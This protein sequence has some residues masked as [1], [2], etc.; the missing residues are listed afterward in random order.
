MM[1]GKYIFKLER[2]QKAKFLINKNSYKQKILKTA[3]KSIKN[4]E[5]ELNTPLILLI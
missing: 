5:N 3:Y 4:Q 2:K 1:I